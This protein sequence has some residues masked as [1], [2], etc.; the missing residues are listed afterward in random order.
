ML[1]RVCGLFGL[2]I[3]YPLERYRVSAGTVSRIRWNGIAYP[4]ERYQPRGFRGLAAFLAKC[5][6]C[7]PLA[8][9]STCTRSPR[10]S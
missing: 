1:A 9:F 5:R 7:G 8:R 3:A 4:L 10:I 2:W 6:R